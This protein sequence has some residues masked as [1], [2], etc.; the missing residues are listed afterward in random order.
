[1]SFAKTSSQSLIK[2]SE[3]EDAVLDFND[4][5]S[6]GTKVPEYEPFNLYVLKGDMFKRM[7]DVFND[8]PLTLQINVDAETSTAI[9]LTIIGQTTSG[10]PIKITFILS[11]TE[12]VFPNGV[13]TNYDGALNYTKPEDGS[14][15]FSLMKDEIE[16]VKKLIKSLHKTNVSNSSYIS[17]SIS[18]EKNI[19]KVFDK[20]FC[21]KFPLTKTENDIN[22]NI[23]DE[24]VEFR[25]L[26]SDFIV[27]GKHTFTFSFN[28]SSQKII[29]TSTTKNNKLSI[30]CATNN[31]G[32]NSAA[33]N[34]AEQVADGV[35]GTDDGV[36]LG[37]DELDDY[38][39]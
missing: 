6:I 2:E 15:T 13:P 1:M 17:I 28:V 24:E 36:D 20:V 38:D 30:S 4:D 26:K 29:M 19:I 10:T 16:E 27:S 12:L 25:I 33:A 3:S 22:E 35:S 32:L 34:G 14:I 23:P 5:G 21:V 8:E 11:D 31:V 39:I 7:I 18:K 37:I 9:D